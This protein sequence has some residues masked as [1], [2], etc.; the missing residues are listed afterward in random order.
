MKANKKEKKIG[1]K[2]VDEMQQKFF[3]TDQHDHNNYLAITGINR[4]FSA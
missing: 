2:H 3:L 1:I 4:R